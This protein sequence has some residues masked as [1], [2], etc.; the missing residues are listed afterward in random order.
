FKRNWAYL[1]VDR[2]EVDE[3]LIEVL[4]TD[5]WPLCLPFVQSYEE[6]TGAPRSMKEVLARMRGSFGEENAQSHSASMIQFFAEDDGEG[7]AF[8]FFDARFLKQRGDLAAYLMHEDWRLP[9]GEGVGGFD[10]EE[11]TEALAP[12]GSGEG[13]TYAVFLVRESKY[14]FDDLMPAA[15]IDGVRLPGLARWLLA[16]HPADEWYSA[17]LRML[18]TLL[19][20]GVTMADPLEQ[21]FLSSILADPTDAASWAAWDDLREER[22]LE[23]PGIGLLRDAF[24]RLARLPGDV[25][26]SLG[27]DDDLAI[28]CG[29]LLAQEAKAK[30]RLSP[31]SLLH[32]EPHLAQMCLDRSH[33]EEPYFG[34]WI[35]F[36][37]LWASAHPAMADALLRWCARWDVL[38]DW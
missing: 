30:L 5:D 14:P 23:P 16:W 36:D 25:Q 18:R 17:Y 19:V 26:D 27:L 6:G 21:A 8:F 9:T 4:D 15:R 24:A 31:K 12:A 22:G 37:D 34:Q 13:T 10:T 1:A 29:Q 7:G 32:L 11:E 2:E 35:L 38:S 28:A 20:A 33:A 3:R